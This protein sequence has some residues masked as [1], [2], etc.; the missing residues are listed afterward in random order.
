MKLSLATLKGLVF[1]I[2]VIPLAKNI[3]RQGHDKGRDAQLGYEQPHEHTGQDA[4][5]QGSQDGDPHIGVAVNHQ[6]TYGCAAQGHD[7]AHTQV[8]V[9]C[10]HT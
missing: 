1:T 4:Y 5:C 2:V 7:G 10:Q 8:D 3:P 9:A 6:D